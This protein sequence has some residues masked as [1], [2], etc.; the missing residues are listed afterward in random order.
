MLT[1]LLLQ[2]HRR[3]VESHLQTALRLHL[4]LACV[5]LSDTQD[6][7]NDTQAQL[8]NLQKEF[9]ETTRELEKKI[10]AV[11]EKK[12]QYSEENCHNDS[13]TWRIDGFSKLLES[14]KSNEIT[15]IESS[16][17]CSCGYKCKLQ[18]DPNGNKS[19]KGTHLAIYVLIMRGEND[20]TLEWPF[21][22]RVV[23]TL[24]DQQ[25][26]DA[27]KQNICKSFHEPHPALE[28]LH[29]FTRPVTVENRFGY[30]YSKFVSHKTLQER[31]YIVDDTII[32]Q[33]AFT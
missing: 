20:A 32:I 1:F 13:F 24:I 11:L 2:I 12:A 8:G 30:G 15:R 29:Y 9:K 21:Q 4:D 14:A 19:G 18:M 10:H 6:Q 16:P 3:E 5:K 25:E 27:S 22:K 28:L 17:F 33:V 31:R 7:L 23:F 26:T